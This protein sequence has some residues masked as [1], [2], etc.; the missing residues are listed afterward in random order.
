MSPPPQVKEGHTGFGVDVPLLVC[1][2][3]LEPVCG[4][5]P[6]LQGYIVGTNSRADLI[7]VTLTSFSKSQVKNVETFLVCTLFF[8]TKR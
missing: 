3:S 5:S 7:L 8:A 2:I 6:N 4:I 1:R